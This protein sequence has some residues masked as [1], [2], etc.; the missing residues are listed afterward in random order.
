MEGRFQSLQ[1]RLAVRL[2]AVF[3]IATAVTVSILVYQAY[4]TAA[5]L[6]ERQLGL[7]AQDLAR[8]I[9][10]DAS[11]SPRLDLPSK[12][13]AEYATAADA[14]VFAI[15]ALNGRIVA[16]SPPSFGERVAAWSAAKDALG[17]FHLKDL[18]PRARE[19]YGLDV[20]ADTA[21]GPLL[22][23]V[24]HEAGASVLIH[25]L[26][27]GFIRHI[28]WV[29]AILVA[30]TLAVGTLAIRSGLNPVRE[31]SKMASAI[32]PG[33]TSIRLP[34]KNLPSEITPLVAAVNRALDRLERGFIVQR[35]FTAN[36]AHQ[37]RT[38]L[39]IVT[40]G[41][42]QIA[43]NGELVKLRADV[44][45]MNRLVEQLL[46]VARLDAIVPDV[47]GTVDLGAVAAEVVASMAPFAIARERSLAI[48]RTEQAVD[49]RGNRYEIEDAIRNLVENAIA[50]TRPQ[51]EVV[52]GVGSDGSVSIADR[53]PGVLVEER[54]LIFDRFWRGRANPSAGAGLGLAIVREIMKAHGGRVR[55][56]DNPGGGAVFTLTFS[57]TPGT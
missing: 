1:W 50:L 22:I 57:T 30:I 14:D 6:T 44:A 42:E 32:G 48:Q 19:Y 40:A 41:L 21:A 36:A 12:L 38:P 49:V 8:S 25:S 31:V 51:T 56:E 45:R 9:A 24:A 4:D 23:A 26:L 13:A 7:R 10:V 47:S 52:V 3:V 17:Y 34:E 33:A 28:A 43:G 55:V 54:E 29:I 46:R 27:R 20:S 18:G 11:G 35:E 39:A 37:L 2:A 15:R 16:A 53:G 5:S